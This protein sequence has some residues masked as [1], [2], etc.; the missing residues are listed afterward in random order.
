M[1]EG[2]SG[3][4]GSCDKR[5]ERERGSV[6]EREPGRILESDRGKEQGTVGKSCEGRMIRGFLITLDT[7]TTAIQL[8]AVSECSNFLF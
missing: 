2:V 4:G 6:G 3:G 7:A 5:R 1:G 8:V